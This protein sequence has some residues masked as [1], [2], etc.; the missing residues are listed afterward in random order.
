MLA[1]QQARCGALVRGNGRPLPAARR[2]AALG[3]PRRSPLAVRAAAEPATAAAAPPAA[4]FA[5]LDGAALAY[6]KAPPSL[7][8]EYSADVKS[9]YESLQSA[10]ALPKWGSGAEALPAR[11]NVFPGELRQ[12]G[13]KNPDKLAVPSI[14]ND[15]AF[16]ASCIAVFSVLAVALGQLPGDWGF[17]GSYLSGAM[18]LVVMGIGSTAPGLL[19]GII[20]QFSQ[21]FPDYRQ[22]V[23]QHEAA[24]FLVGYLLGV[25]VTGYSVAMTREHTEFAE[26]KLQARIF[27]RDLS[28]DDVNSLAAVS[29]AGIA[30]EGMAHEEVMGQTADL[31]DLQRILLRQRPP[32]SNAQQQNISRWAVWAAATLLRRHKAEHEALQAALAGGASLAECVRAIEGAGDAAAAAKPAAA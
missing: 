22:R 2:A 13:I 5:E 11:R 29:V 23:L 6:K 8:L 20:D 10:G 28:E 25:P 24:H 30:A 27:Q 32:L 31:M 9:A 15:A 16:L 7:K 18:I 26:A 19:Q 3:A 14:R 4:L 17:F 1:A 21:I 12:M